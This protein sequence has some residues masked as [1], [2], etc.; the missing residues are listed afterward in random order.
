MMLEIYEG[1]FFRTREGEKAGPMIRKPG[2][3]MF[4]WQGKVLNTPASWTKQGRA[5]ATGEN[6][7]DL[8]AEWVDEKPG[9]VNGKP[10][11]VTVVDEPVSIEEAME[12]IAKGVLAQA[13]M[14]TD[15]DPPELEALL[16]EVFPPDA[17][18]EAMAKVPKTK[19][20]IVAI[21]KDAPTLGEVKDLRERNENQAQ[22]IADNDKL[23]KSAS[24][25]IVRL[26]GALA[27]VKLELDHAK[28]QIGI[29]ESAEERAVAEL[30]KAE[31][32]NEQ[33]KIA[34]AHA[35]ATIRDREETIGKLEL[36]LNDG[37][38]QVRYP[39]PV[40]HQVAMPT[41]FRVV[42]LPHLG[43]YVVERASIYIA[44]FTEKADLVSWL[45]NAPEA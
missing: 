34:A 13:D 26:T 29:L 9:K 15:D 31:A 25:E 4:V 17:E 14:P 22:T 5:R 27:E 23:M 3:K 28:N 21:L 7:Y 10:G 42:R 1:G 38:A 35:R 18:A 37:V 30:K 24:D 2:A 40:P 6:E 43:G 33:F 36:A 44:A 41:E 16:A 11:P 12:E 19:E 8:I 39:V 32:E 20:E 45:A